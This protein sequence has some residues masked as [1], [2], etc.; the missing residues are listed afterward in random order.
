MADLAM[1]LTQNRNEAKLIRAYIGTRK[2]SRTMSI[3]WC[4]GQ[5]STHAEDIHLCSRFWE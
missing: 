1:Q 5:F 3:E 2:R 4:Q